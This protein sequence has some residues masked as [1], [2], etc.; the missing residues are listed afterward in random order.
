ML[1]HQEFRMRAVIGIALAFVGVGLAGRAQAQAAAGGLELSGSS[2]VG[3]WTCRE[4]TVHP[5]PASPAGVPGR[6][7][8][9]DPASGG[10]TLRFPVHDID[11][12]DGTM[13]DKLRQA[14]QADRHPM[15]S[16]ALTSEQLSRA[17]QAE[18]APVAVEGALT[19]AGRT[20]PVQTQV[21]VT[22]AAGHALRVRGEQVLRMS[23]FGVKPPR[24][25]L[26]ALKVRDLVHVVFD[27]VLRR[28]PL[29]LH[30]P[31]GAGIEPRR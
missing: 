8:A 19:I 9:P 1:S 22:P 6:T 28:P 25:L 30:G 20:E 12:G 5:A 13:N 31:A 7:R 17:V 11:C 2:T 23:A 4:P 18:S 24:L 16:F 10:M 21:T 14:L 3:N 15:I 27:L 29:A 26:G